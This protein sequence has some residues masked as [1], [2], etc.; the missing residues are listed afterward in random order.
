MRILTVVTQAFLWLP[1]LFISCYAFGQNAQAK[2]PHIKIIL[3]GTFHFRDTPDKNRT[4]F[5]DLLSVKR[6]AQLQSF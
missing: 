5:D 6:Q 2:L 1:L 3:V 4:T